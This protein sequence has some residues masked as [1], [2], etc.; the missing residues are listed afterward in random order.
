MKMCITA[1][2]KGLDSQIDPRFGRCAY[3]IIVDSETKKFQSISNTSNV[4][5]HGAGIQA[6]QIVRNEGV[7]TVITGNVGP[8]AYQA[9]ST[10]G[11]KIITGASGNVEEVIDKFNKGTLKEVKSPT[12]SG[13][14]G[15]GGGRGRGRRM[16]L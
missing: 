1:T 5:A 16:D 12:V 10:A 7:E 6:A 4:A 9:L 3:F 14:F 2:N 11:I 8:N 15:L 13:H